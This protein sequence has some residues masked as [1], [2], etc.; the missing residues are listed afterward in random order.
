MELLTTNGQFLSHNMKPMSEYEFL[1]KG[2]FFLNENIKRESIVTLTKSDGHLN[3]ISFI[4]KLLSQTSTEEVTPN[5]LK[6]YMVNQSVSI[7]MKEV[8]TIFNIIL[9]NHGINSLLFSSE[10]I[11]TCIYAA[12]KA[13]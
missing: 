8:Y 9:V 12:C 5:A 1:G 10:L 13:F 2:N 7:L 11:L 3:I 4:I 6:K